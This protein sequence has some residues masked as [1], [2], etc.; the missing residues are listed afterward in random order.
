MTK[1]ELLYCLK[2]S[3]IFSGVK[4][5]GLL[6]ILRHMKENT[7]AKGE[8][9]F[10]EGDAGDSLHI[11]TSGVLKVVK[12]SKDGKTKTL[13]ILNKK[14]GFG[15]MALF[16][17]EARS[18]TVEALE[19][20]RT[21]SISREDFEDVISKEPSISLQIIKSLSERLAKADRDIKILAHGDA[22][23]R[24]ACV[25]MDFKDNQNQVKFSHQEIG[26]LAGLSRETTTRVLNKLEK[27][28]YVKV[29]HKSVMIL[30]IK[31]MK[32]LCI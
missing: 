16:T 31:K 26:D 20:T 14:D 15:E 28:G 4:S 3:Y 8:V 21:L 25:L 11:I 9:I 7:F 1:R 10:S 32:E 2:E 13:A 23:S 19:E 18:A 30:D 17:K 29:R 22:N 6:I 24:V 12:Y 27:E 5:S